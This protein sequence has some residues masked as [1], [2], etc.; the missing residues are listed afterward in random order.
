MVCRVVDIRTRGAILL[1]SDIEKWQLEADTRIYRS[2][3]SSCRH[4]NS[5]SRL[6]TENLTEVEG[7]DGYIG[8]IPVDILVFINIE[9]GCH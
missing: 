9:L 6:D 8:N 3:R 2:R 5:R 4:R 7:S 1:A